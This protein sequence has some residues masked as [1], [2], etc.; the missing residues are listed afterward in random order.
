[1]L[2]R[3]RQLANNRFVLGVELLPPRGYESEPAIQRARELK[4]YGVDVVNIPDGLRSGA[5]VSALALAL[6]GN[7]DEDHEC[8]CKRKRHRVC[9]EGG[10]PAECPRKHPSNG[11][12]N[13]KHDTPH[14][15]EERE[16]GST[17]GPAS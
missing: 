7:G 12:P 17:R 8:R 13:S 4:R 10:I 3:S 1:M 14:G 2:F 5:R 15:A 9:D 11:G 6:H 16:P